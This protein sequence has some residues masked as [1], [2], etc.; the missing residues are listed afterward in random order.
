MPPIICWGIWIARNRC[1]FQDKETTVGSIVVQASSIYLN[2]SNSE[3]E[4]MHIHV[5]EEKIKDG[6][7]WAY[8]DEASQ[9][10][11]VGVGLIIH[12]NESYSLKSSIGLGSGS[13]NFV[14]LYALKLL[15]CWLIHRNI[16][17]VQIFGIH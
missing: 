17:T 8:F 15:L 4:R 1:I 7:P 16:L 14:E 6:V 2:I 13:N 9:N 10:N 3:E 5:E 12:I 11:K